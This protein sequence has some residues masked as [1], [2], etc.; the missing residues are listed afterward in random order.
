MQQSNQATH[1]YQTDEVDLTKLAKTLKERRW[2]I[3]GFTAIVTL[4]AIIY[5]VYLMLLPPSP[6]G[7]TVKATF[8][9]PSESSV[10]QLNRTGFLS[11]TR[12]TI[13]SS[14]LSKL[15]DKAFQK[16]IF[17]EG[18]YLT[19]LNKENLPIDDVDKY[20][21]GFLDSGS[22]TKIKTKETKKTLNTIS[23][24]GTALNSFSIQGTNR[25]ILVE[26][27]N[28]LVVKS[29]NKT[30][31][32]Y[33]SL[34][35]Q[36]IAFRLD[37]ITVERG[38]LLTKA[39]QDRL[40]HI[41]RIKEDDAGRIR[42]IND[43]IDRV[44]FRAK[45]QRLN[46]IIALTDAA[47]IAKS[48]GIIDNNF[49]SISDHGVIPNLIIAIGENQQ[50][51]QWYLYGEKALLKRIE[52]LENRTSDD[53]F[54][55]ELIILTS[56]L[57]EIQNNNR[58]KTLIERQDDIPF[59]ARINVLDIEKIKLESIIL[60]SSSISSMQLNQGA[61]FQK[62]QNIPQN[63]IKKIVSLAFFGGF[64]LSI[65]LVLMMNLFKEDETEPTTKTSR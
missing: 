13:H 2:F 12:E 38:L 17:I 32:D 61:N 64:I 47:I 26:F 57:I 44:R 29:D 43:E 11:E 54:I 62:I 15:N 59:V 28:E 36:K 24:Q 55:P 22:L 49:K 31:S 39:L 14:F 40:S 34:I 6:I 19:K 51:P 1:P 42:E 53:P 8:F 20:I 4:L 30:V 3:F 23:V 35:K 63:N 60:E 16:K 56:K 37:E 65:V 21:Y 41:A 58:L 50:L 5:V 25:E 7:Y 48:I 45:Q 9:K 18:D 10:L 52:L 46:E 33:I 27:L